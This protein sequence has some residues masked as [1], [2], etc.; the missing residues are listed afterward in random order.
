M[1]EVLSRREE[2][3]AFA[4]GPEKRAERL[5]DVSLIV[6]DIDNLIRRLDEEYLLPNK[7]LT[8]CGTTIGG[9][10]DINGAVP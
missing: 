8:I 10:R 3:H 6:H 1:K 9:N 5:S 4:V 2:A 7:Q